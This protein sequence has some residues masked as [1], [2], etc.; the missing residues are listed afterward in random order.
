MTHSSWFLVSVFGAALLW[1]LG[2]SP[3]E[4]ASD[5]VPQSLERSLPVVVEGRSTG[6]HGLRPCGSSMSANPFTPNTDCSPT[7]ASSPPAG[8]LPPVRVQDVV[9]AL[10]TVDPCINAAHA[11]GRS[12]HAYE[13]TLAHQLETLGLQG[14]TGARVALALQLQKQRQREGYQ[15]FD[16]QQ[17]AQDTQLQ[18]AV[19]LLA[20][21]AAA[22]DTQALAIRDR[23]GEEERRLLHTGR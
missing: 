22:G 3:W 10:H 16:H 1:A 5:R 17:V 4:E 7:S 18:R 11:C 2:L 20:E 14:D 8:G 13:S 6:A 21:S 23:L 12:P 15:A 19:A 9:D